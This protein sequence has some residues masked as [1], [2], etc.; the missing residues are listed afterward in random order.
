MGKCVNCGTNF[1]GTAENPPK[2]GLCRY[3]ELDQLK[4]ALQESVKL[5]SHYGQLLNAYDG[6]T[7]LKFDSAEEWIKRLKQTG[8]LK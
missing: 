5:Q 8:T 6:G 7:R 1:V 2:D 3:C 4:I